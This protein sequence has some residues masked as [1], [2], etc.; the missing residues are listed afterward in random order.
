MTPRIL[1]RE[2][3][4]AARYSP[5]PSALVALVAAAM[6]FAAII[7][8]GRQAAIEASVAEELSGPDARSLTIAD[9]TGE[10]V[11]TPPTIEVLGAIEQ[12]SAVLGRGL[13]ID[14]VNGALGDGGAKVALIEIHG[15]VTDVIKIRTGRAP[16]SGEALVP[17]ALLD[18]LRLTQPSGYLEA[19]DGRQWAIVGSFEPIAPFDDLSSTAIA[20]A[21]AEADTAI[22]EI[23]VVA[24]EA[25]YSAAVRDA[26]LAIIDPN[27]E[28]VT[29]SDP[30]A[31][32]ATVQVV[33]G[34]LAG[35]GRS[36]LL[37]ILGVGSFF[38]G[39]VVLADVLI[40]QRDLG[41][42]RTLGITR[43]G[44]VALVSLRTCAPAAVGAALGAVAA[45]ALMIGQSNP[46]PWD[47][48]AATPIIALIT[49]TLMSLG[50]AGY[51]ASRDPVTIMRTP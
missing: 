11:T 14:V 17:N 13:P 34:E 35:F 26:A 8:V 47:F 51:A 4:N 9:A 25:P 43:L 16:E 6:C 5:V 33:S 22:Q 23:T 15:E 42:R 3:I 37:L 24:A 38:V 7:T 46:V 1:L 49:A 19:A 28:N 10:G 41:R 21:S 44:L 2:S 12:V 45:Q 36:L 29:I 31:A 18:K 30:S 39:T 20:M 40:R 50:P 27:P 32:S 48:V